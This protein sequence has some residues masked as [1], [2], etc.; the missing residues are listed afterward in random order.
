MTGPASPRCRASRC[1]CS[2]ALPGPTPMTPRPARGRPVSSADSRD[3]PRGPPAATKV[4]FFSALSAAQPEGPPRLAVA[5]DSY[6]GE[7]FDCPPLNA[8][9]L[10]APVDF[11][12]RLVQH[13]GRVLRSW[14]RKSA[15]EVPA[16]LAIATGGLASSLTGRAPGYTGPRGPRSPSQQFVTIQAVERSYPGLAPTGRESRIFRCIPLLTCTVSTRERT[17]FRCS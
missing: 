11:K 14:P 1:G 9:F 4:A 5:A 3:R 7:G 13:A 10:A 2:P 8:L 15:A 17:P 16:Y 12:G 6:V